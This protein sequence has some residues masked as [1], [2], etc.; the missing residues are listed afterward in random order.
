MTQTLPATDLQPGLALRYGRIP[1]ELLTFQYA[2]EPAEP[3]A[4]TYGWYVHEFL[5]AGVELD[6]NKLPYEPNSERGRPA[7]KDAPQLAFRHLEHAVERAAEQYT[8]TD[9]AVAGWDVVETDVWGATVVVPRLEQ[10]RSTVTLWF[11]NG[12]RLVVP[13]MRGAD[14]RHVEG[15]FRAGVT[16][17]RLP[18][19]PTEHGTTNRWVSAR[20][21]NMIDVAEQSTPISIDDLT[22]QLTPAAETLRRAMSDLSMVERGGDV[23]ADDTPWLAWEALT[24]WRDK[25]PS[26]TGTFWWKTHEISKVLSAIDKA[27]RAAGGWVW[28]CDAPVSGYRFVPT[29]R[30][31]RLVA[32]RKELA[33]PDGLNH[34]TTEQLEARVA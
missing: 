31:E 9:V 11:A 33:G 17:L 19:I 29:E 1:N 20:Q 25:G 16:A 12:E 2:F 14:A 3:P 6:E 30:W 34:V 26:P 7:D 23:W 18:A 24:A 21:L 13:G 32:L 10:R 27:Q 28:N 22:G 15:T 8:T 4:A 5:A